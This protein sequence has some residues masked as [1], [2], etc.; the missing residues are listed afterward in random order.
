M[1]TEE[2]SRKYLLN[3]KNNFKI[4]LQEHLLAHIYLTCLLCGLQ[5][6]PPMLYRL[7]PQHIYRQKKLANLNIVEISLEVSQK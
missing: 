7:D 6:C 3:H 5:S 4:R 2:A 1:K